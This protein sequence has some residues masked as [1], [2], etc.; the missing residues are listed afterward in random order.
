MKE[1]G[2]RVG[3]EYNVGND[4]RVGEKALPPGKA[5]WPASEKGSEYVGMERCVW[6]EK[7]I[8]V[9]KLFDRTVRT[10]RRSP[11]RSANR[12]TRTAALRDSGSD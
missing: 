12:R 10:T 5:T 1:G 9:F 6:T 11:S 8:H 7:K 4:G 2:K 3:M